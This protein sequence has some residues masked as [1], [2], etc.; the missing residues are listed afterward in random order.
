M[1]VITQNINVTYISAGSVGPYAFNFPISDPTALRVIVNSVILASTDYT[2]S[3]VNNNYDNGGSVTLVLSPT[4]GQTIILQRATPLT[5]ESVFTDNV[6]QPMQQFEEALDKLTE[7]TQELAA[8]QGSGG[9]GSSTVV[10]QGPGIIVT[11]T[12]TVSNPYVISLAAGFGIASFTGGKAGELGQT[13]TNP[14]FAVSYSGTPTG[15]TLTNTDNVDSPFHLLTPF[16]SAPLVG[17]FTHGTTATTT[18]TLTATNGVTS[19]TATQT[20]TWSERIFG[21]VGAVGAT[22]TVTA[23]GNNAVLSTTDVIPSAGLGAES[24]GQT[25]GPFSPSGQA[26]YLLLTGGGHTFTDAISGFPFAFNAPIAVTFVN[27]FGV[28][29]SMFLYQSTNPLTGNFQPRISS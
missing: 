6:P 2:I 24:V 11:G 29:L 4:A 15:A 13:F 27:Q 9:G 28:S 5:Q 18:F 3:P 16:T 7:I 10:T 26:V 19:P 8:N 23:S 20:F 14:S 1:S 21:G 22:A 25:F 17:S 12:G